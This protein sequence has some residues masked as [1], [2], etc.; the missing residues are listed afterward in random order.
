MGIPGSNR[1]RVQVKFDLENTAF[2]KGLK[3]VNDKLDNTQKQI[4]ENY[5]ALSDSLIRM[6][7]NILMVL[8]GITAA[9]AALAIPSIKLSGEFERLAVTFEVLSGNAEKA[10]QLIKEI[11]E[12][13]AKTPLQLRDIQEAATLMLAF[14]YSIDEVLPKLELFGQASAALRVPMEQIIRVR[15]FLAGGQFRA[16]ML[17]PLGITRREMEQFGAVFGPSGELLTGAEESLVIFDRML[18]EY[19]GLFD[20]IFGTLTA[21]TANIVDQI[22][23]TFAGIGDALKPIAVEVMDWLETNL[24]RLREWLEA[25]QATVTAAFEELLSTVKPVFVAMS[26]AVE[27]F[28]TALEKDPGMLVRLAQ[29]INKIVKALVA[30]LIINTVIIGVIK[31]ATAI[32]FLTTLLEMLHLTWSGLGKFLIGPWPIAIGIAIIGL[33]AL[34]FAFQRQSEAA[35]EARDAY[36]ELLEEFA[37]SE[38]LFQEIIKTLN[39]V[40]D[41]TEFTQEQIDYLKDK[42]VEL[43]DTFPDLL[44][45]FGFSIDA[46]GLLVDATGT[47]ITELDILQDVINQFNTSVIVDEARRGAEALLIL[48]QARLLEAAGPEPVTRGEREAIFTEDPLR[49]E[50][51]QDI[52]VLFSRDVGTLGRALQE[53]IYGTTTTAI[54]S[55]EAVNEAAW[56]DLRERFLRLTREGGA[57]GITVPTDRDRG[58]GA[59]ERERESLEHSTATIDQFTQA[60]DAHAIAERAIRRQLE[61]RLIDEKEAGG[62]LNAAKRTLIDTLIDLD[63]EFGLTNSQQAL[64]NALTAEYI[65]VLQDAEWDIWLTGLRD[66]NQ[67]IRDNIIQLNNMA[68]IFMR[69]R[70]FFKPQ[71]ERELSPEEFFR[72]LER[73]AGRERAE[74]W[75]GETQRGEPP[76]EEM[77]GALDESV[78][79]VYRTWRERIQEGARLLGESIVTG[80]ISEALRYV[81]NTLASHIAERIQAM[82][83]QHGLAALGGVAGGIIG[84]FVGWGISQL[85]PGQKGS[86]PSI[87][88]YAHVVNFPEDR[89]GAYLPFSFLF[90][91]RSNVYD[92]DYRGASLDRMRTGRR[93]GFHYGK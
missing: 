19:S 3:D 48:S 73:E 68:D 34:Q 37:K 52:A 47:V 78:K 12:F 67:S 71:F 61:L 18:A 65:Q 5:G 74:E 85:M 70:A 27:R 84:A 49:L 11:K 62:Q 77:E 40:N 64:L 76:L 36:G 23:L 24:G 9:F 86:T 45:Q 72:S 7:R 29:N 82:L 4:R 21:R 83:A 39:S 20:R 17:A 31:F 16:T 1:Y 59:R 92:V 93:L 69:I 81:F 30:M 88:I 15:E 53:A 54:E 63:A 91:G 66:F 89:L 42:L 90:S 50:T 57:P 25:N 6:N 35:N 38:T 14:G 41:V 44:E 32:T 26:E 58:G 87:P 56:T 28:M 2:V 8:G 33:V 51:W 46:E 22:E 60:M 10:Q 13:A 79:E 55:A 75:W 80:D 43:N